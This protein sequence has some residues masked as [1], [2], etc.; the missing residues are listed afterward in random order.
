MNALRFLPGCRLQAVLRPDPTTLRLIVT[1]SRRAT[2]RCPACGWRSGSVHGHYQRHATDRPCFERRV[3]LAVRVRRFRG[4]NPA[5][6]RRT[7]SQPPEGLLARHAQRTRRLVCAQA[8]VGVALGGEAAARLLDQL[9]MPTSATT[10]LRMVRALPMATPEVP[11]VP[12]VDDW[13]MKRSTTYGDNPGW[14]VAVIL[15]RYC[16]SPSSCVEVN[17]SKFPV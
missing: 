5:C 9:G 17:A 2:C 10:V 1:S 8:A 11:R 16:G 14:L 7:F 13:A 6:P 3:L 4:R 12:G 15:F